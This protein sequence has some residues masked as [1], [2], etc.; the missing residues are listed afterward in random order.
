MKHHHGS[1]SRNR[2]ATCWGGF[3]L[4]PGDRRKVIVAVPIRNTSVCRGYWWRLGCSTVKVYINQS[5]GRSWGHWAQRTA[6][7]SWIRCENVQST[8][9]GKTEWNKIQGK[10]NGEVPT[11]STWLQLLRWGTLN[12]N[13]ISEHN[14]WFCIPTCL[15]KGKKTIMG[16]INQSI[17]LSTKKEKEKKKC[18]VIIKI[19]CSIF[20]T[21]QNVH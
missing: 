16:E 1:L 12:I 9:G 19:F 7:G 6:G 15:R 5:A 18:F 10:T 4:S 20:M 3:T 14:C 11:H 2:W 13:V 21:T 8:R 17:Y